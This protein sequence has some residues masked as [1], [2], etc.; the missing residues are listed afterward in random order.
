M[1]RVGTSFAWFGSAL[2][3]RCFVERFVDL[4]ERVGFGLERRSRGLDLLF[5]I[6]VLLKDLLI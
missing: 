2:R 6:V 3:N 5:E 1:A 4:V